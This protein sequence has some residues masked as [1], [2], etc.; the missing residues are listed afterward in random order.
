MKPEQ[1]FTPFI[2]SLAFTNYL[3][4]QAEQSESSRRVQIIA[5]GLR[6]S[7]AENHPGYTLDE[8][9]GMV[10][11]VKFRVGGIN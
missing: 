6:E 5:D 11:E 8:L 3:C 2:A 10:A 9:A 7:D 1:K 4:E